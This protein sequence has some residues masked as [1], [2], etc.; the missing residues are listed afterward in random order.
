MDNFFLLKLILNINLETANSVGLFKP[1]NRT[2][3]WKNMLNILNQSIVKLLEKRPSN[4]FFVIY[5]PDQLLGSL[6]DGR[7]AMAHT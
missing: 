1:I 3:I 7:T 5:Y 4:F 2:Q 6:Q